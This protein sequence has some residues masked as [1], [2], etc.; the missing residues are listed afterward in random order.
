MT[1]QLLRIQ[2]TANDATASF[3]V[4][5]VRLYNVKIY[6]KSTPRPHV[7]QVSE[8]RLRNGVIS[9]RLTDANYCSPRRTVCG[10]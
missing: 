8:L 4:K 2:G 1:F 10:A 5:A 3:R 7:G 6:W 9:E